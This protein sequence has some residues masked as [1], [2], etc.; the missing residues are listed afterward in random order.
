MK[1]TILAFAFALLSVAAL[2][3]SSTAARTQNETVSTPAPYEYSIG[4]RINWFSATLSF[5]QYN[6]EGTKATDYSVQANFHSKE[7]F[8]CILKETVKRPFLTSISENAIEL[9]IGAGP[10]LGTW[11][12]Y[13]TDG[14]KNRLALGLMG[15][16]GLEYKFD[17]LP[18]AA[19]VDYRP[20]VY[21]RFSSWEG[22]RFGSY[23][24]NIGLGARLTF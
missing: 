8:V 6:S 22:H 13:D 1:K 12:Y 5:R 15:V 11:R 7:Y 24:G 2:A 23:I 9:Y 18:L 20:G 16:A 14:T 21:F 3:Q 19:F 17:G 4:G 10:M